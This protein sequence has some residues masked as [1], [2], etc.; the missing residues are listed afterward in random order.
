MAGAG[1]TPQFRWPSV[2]DSTNKVVR[3]TD[4]SGSADCTIAEGTFFWRDD[5][6]ADDWQVRFQAALDAAA[7]ATGSGVTY[8][9]SLLDSGFITILA[10]GGVFVLEW[11]H[12]NTTADRT[13]FGF[14]PGPTTSGGSVTSDFQVGNAWFPEQIYVDDS[15]D[16]P[17]YRGQ[18]TGIM[19]GRTR[20]QRWGSLTKR[21]ILIDVLHP[22]KVFQAEE[23]VP[24]ESFQRF[25]AWLSTGGRFEFCRNFI[26]AKATWSTYVLDPDNPTA[27]Q[28]WPA[29]IPHGTIRRYDVALAMQRYVA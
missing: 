28:A 3:Y 15:E 23:T 2:I 19:N 25:Q 21:Q 22:N 7:V 18:I 8:T 17:F 12:A 1:T 26:S 16:V 13:L 5:A 9:V 27:I 29:T 20:T 10:S 14:D 4:L 11:N 24:N 6:T